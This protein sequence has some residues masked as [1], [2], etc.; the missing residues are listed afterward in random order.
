MACAAAGVLAACAGNRW[1]VGSQTVVESIP[2]SQ[3]GWVEKSAFEKG[4]TFYYHGAVTGRSDM[5][6]A[7]RE[8]RA[9]GEKAVVEQIRQTIRTE[10][11]SSMEGQNVENNTGSYVR[12]LLAKV[13][14]NV[15][16]SG[17]SQA[18]QYVQKIEEETSGGVRYV[19][20][21]H[22]LMG[23]SRT[24]YEEARRRAFEGALSKAHAEN[25]AKAEQALNSAFQKLEGA[26]PVSAQR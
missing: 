19:W 26:G 9:E 15:E 24:D 13:S 1:R 11:G 18:E 2:A 22:V 3:P 21:C 23:L 14:E 8:A 17:V 16:V 12:D 25:N 6:L 7:L 10:F 20:N 5:A 4:G